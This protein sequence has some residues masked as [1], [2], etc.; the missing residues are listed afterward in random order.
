VDV[1]LADRLV[2]VVG[3]AGAGASPRY[4]YGSGC[5]VA[6]RTVLTA[7]H[8]IDGCVA[9][10]VRTAKKDLWTGIVD[11]RF[12]GQVSGPAPDLALVEIDNPA[13]DLPALPLARLDRDSVIEAAVQCHAFGYPWFAKRPSPTTVR[14]VVDAVGAIPILSKLATGLASVQVRDSPRALPPEDRTLADSAWSGMSGGPVISGGRLIGVVIEHAPRE[15]QSSITI[16]PLSLLERHP[17]YPRWGPGVSDPGAWWRRLGVD[18]LAG[19]IVLPAPVAS[20]VAEPSLSPDA[21]EQYS[22]A[23]AAAGITPPVHWT[24][25]ALSRI[26]VPDSASRVRELISAL[27]R[28]VRAKPVLADLGVDRLGLAQLQVIY[29]REVGAWPGDGSADALLVQA[30]EVEES[31]RR[32]GRT[33]VLGALA[34]F[35]TG[36]AAALTVPPTQH[37][38]LAAWIG[39][40]G[41]Q[42]ADAEWRY[43]DQLGARAWLLLDL[44]AEPRF[45]AT[46]PWP[47]RIT[48]THITR[49]AGTTTK[50]TGE[51]SAAPTRDGLSDALVAIFAA[52]PPTHQ[53]L[54]D[55]AI[56]A[57]LLDA[58]IEHWPLF[59]DSLADRHQARLRWSQRLHDLYLRSKCVERTARSTWTTM[60]RALTE[61]VLTDDARLQRWI[62]DDTVHAWLIGRKPPAARSDPLRALLKAGYGFLVWFP[63]TAHP[64]SSGLI[65]RAVKR[66]P[67]AARRTVIPDEVLG[68]PGGHLVIWDDPRGRGDEFTLPSPMAAQ[69]LGRPT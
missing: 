8:V 21:M 44:G 26:A 51:Q 66:I 29:R 13:V 67:V 60:P 17:G 7:A 52:L 68:L 33:G 59:P 46:A 37:P 62:R 1:P 12:V 40:L 64:R 69:P 20:A 6:G 49:H 4:R 34:R 31:E 27:R 19:L 28:A 5:I 56:P 22:V 14:D 35:V 65:T 36:V 45:G 10:H 25:S 61:A 9:V 23:F 55:L 50:L 42:V 48:W 3:D 18:S 38:G 53:L 54:V 57:A 16:A 47:N 2:Q 63:A 30:A 32:T 11:L 24:A 39:S 58:G 43:Q 15:G 41:Y